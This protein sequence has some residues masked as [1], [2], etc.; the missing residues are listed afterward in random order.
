MA[1]TSSTNRTMP[2][3]ASHR[4]MDNQEARRHRLQHHRHL[5]ERLRTA[6]IRL[7]D[8]DQ[9]RTWAVVSAH[10]QGLSIRQIAAAVGLSP[11]R[12]HQLLTTPEASR[13]PAWLS[14]L[15]EADALPLG[16]AAAGAP[17]APLGGRL[18]EEVAALRQ[19][20][21]WLDDL[22]QNATVVVNL[23]PATEA[24]TEFVPFDRAQVLRVVG[25]IAADLDAL[26]QALGGEQGAVLPEAD[27]PAVRHRRRLIEPPPPSPRL[28]QREERNRRR[29][30]A[31]LPPLD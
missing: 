1:H 10:Q 29:A 14:R 11:T 22:E 30:A 26:A 2:R 24:E 8:A 17:A 27:A 5:V 21:A 12:I 25:R 9:E 13:I 19:C 28:S 23:R 3:R 31:G 4:R 18:A 6:A 15:R 20:L 7:A 16:T